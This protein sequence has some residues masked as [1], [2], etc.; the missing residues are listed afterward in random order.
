MATVAGP[1]HCVLFFRDKHLPNQCC[2]YGQSTRTSNLKYAE[3]AR[4]AISVEYTQV[5]LPSAFSRTCSP[6]WPYHQHENENR[7]IESSKIRNRQDPAQTLLTVSA[8]DCSRVVQVAPPTHSLEWCVFINFSPPIYHTLPLGENR[9]NMKCGWKGGR[10]LLSA[11]SF[12]K[13]NLLSARLTCSLKEYEHL[14]FTYF[15]RQWRV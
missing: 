10:K 1:W 12:R 4:I 13:S 11:L 2:S 6:S 9:S 8:C 5:L 7:L 15:S 14:M 3:V